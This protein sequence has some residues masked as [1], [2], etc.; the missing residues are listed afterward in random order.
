MAKHKILSLRKLSSTLQKLR[1]K[2]NKIVFTNGTFDILHTGHLTYLE[3][4][5]ILGDILIVGVNSDASVKTYKDPS[6]P[7]NP[8]S[9]RMQILAAL[10]CVDYVVEFDEPTPIRLIKICRPDVLVKGGDWKKDQI[11]G[12]KEVESWGG[13]VKIL[14]YLKDR[15]T[16]GILKKLGIA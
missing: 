10:E 7:I 4:A 16:T 5:R 3:K 11:A 2:K 9:D 14:P 13:R 8:V 15:S 1:R 12:A 6:R